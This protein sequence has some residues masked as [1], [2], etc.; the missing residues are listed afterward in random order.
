MENSAINMSQPQMTRS[1]HLAKAL[2]LQ[3]WDNATK[4]RSPQSTSDTHLAL[5]LQV[6]E[7]VP[8]GCGEA[9][10]LGGCTTWGSACQDMSTSMHCE[11]ANQQTRLYTTLQ[12]RHPSCF[13]QVCTKRQLSA[14]RPNKHDCNSAN[15]L[16]P[17]PPSWLAAVFL[18]KAL[19]LV[20]KKSLLFSN[21]AKRSLKQKVNC[22]KE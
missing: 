13:F 21:F 7:T 22:R 19:F 2:A 18:L 17:P 20:Y 9:A 3:M 5:P 15:E 1:T 12:I 6:W 11:C 16:A 14:G 10:G 8:W 4:M